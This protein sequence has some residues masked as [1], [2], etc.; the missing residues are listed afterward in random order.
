[1]ETSDSLEVVFLSLNEIQPNP[2][3]PRVN[4]QAVSAV[5]E[6]I[7]LFGFKVPIVVGEGNLILAGHTRYRAAAMLGLEKV[8]CIR[9]TDL[10]DEEAAA[11]TVAE[12]RTSDFAS[13]DLAR[14]GDFVADIPE[15]LLA[16]FDIDSLLAG[17]NSDAEPDSKQNSEKTK[18][19]KRDGLDLRPFEKYQYLTIIC[20]TEF[21]YT[22]LLTRF[23][24][25]NIQKGYVDG[26][27][28][29]GSSYG[30]VIEYIDFVERLD[31]E[32]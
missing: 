12:N 17:T 3:N 22:N 5:A 20:R 23:G 10:T 18:P 1:M 25:K 24:L 16:A 7:R 30:R 8:P 6:S 31:S 21:D 32:G 11:F 28:K 9:A 27:L 26:T 15:N 19:E 13:F 4:S 29:R 14:L 2:D